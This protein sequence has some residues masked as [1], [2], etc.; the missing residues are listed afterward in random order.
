MHGFVETQS[1]DI[2]P[3]EARAQQPRK[4]TGQLRGIEQRGEFHA[5]RARVRLDTPDQIAQ[6]E[7]HPGN[8]HRPG[9]DATQAIDTLF[10]WVMFEQI[11]QLIHGGL[12]YR[13]C[14]SASD[15]D[16]LNDIDIALS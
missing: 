14:S 8:H 6:R 13:H 1:L 4:L 2:G 11:F 16:K 9:L 5:L 10:Q 15:R 7:T 12:F 3:V